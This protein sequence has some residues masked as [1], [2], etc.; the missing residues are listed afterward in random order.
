MSR[1]PIAHEV[2]AERAAWYRANGWWDSWSISAG[3]PAAAAASPDAL[4]VAD[5]RTQLSWRELEAAVGSAT[6]RLSAAGIRRGHVV[7]LVMG[8]SVDGVIAFHACI[9]SG[10]AVVLLDRKC[11]RADLDAARGLIDG[12]AP[13]L[14]PRAEIERLAPEADHW[15]LVLESLRSD[16]ASVHPF[17]EA[18]EPDRDEPAVVLLTSGTSG[19]P[20]AVVH[21]LNTLAAGVSNMVTITACSERDVLLLVSPLSSITG[22]M[23]LGLSERQRAPLVV[24]DA[25][26]PAGTLDRMNEVG[27]TLL[28]GAPVIMERILGAAQ[29]RNHR[30]ISLR[31]M[32]LGGAMLPRPLLELAY[33]TFGIDAA[34]VYGSS[35]APNFSGS[36]PG[37]GRE[38]RLSDDGALMPGNE[39]RIGSAAHPE[40]G[41]LRGPCVFLGYLDPEDDAA[42]FEGEWLRTGDLLEERDG[43][44]TATGR[45][46]EIVN[47][48]GLKFSPAEIDAALAGL[49]G[50]VEFAAYGRPDPET[51]ERLAV[52]LRL[53]HDVQLGLSAVVQHLVSRGVAKRK[54]PEELVLW[55]DPLPRT[56]SGKIIRSQLQRDS[57][58]RPC[59]VAERLRRPLARS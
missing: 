35:E 33:D 12:E 58:G 23:Q 1:L 15:A 9:R 22:V 59:E 44:V 47:R 19:R 30:R 20:K 3:L 14:V 2:S 17:A 29:Q 10:I 36:L 48:N 8:N 42:A 11:G 16:A 21:S 50:V 37:D 24:T 25:F 13:A 56:T 49:S 34:R 32:A 43:R 45:L 54:L 4:A 40:E 57:A 52:A 41:M 38:R 39:V 5:D 46:K 53:E 26:D 55:S 6:S 31:T 18:D 28:G 27:A 7:V 51:G